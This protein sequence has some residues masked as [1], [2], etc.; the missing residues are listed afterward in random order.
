MQS[1]LR[2]NY[3]NP[4]AGSEQAADPLLLKEKHAICIL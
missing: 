1:T 3:S 4:S 2:L